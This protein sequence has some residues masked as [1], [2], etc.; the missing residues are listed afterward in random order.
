MVPTHHANER[1]E[2]DEREQLP[3]GWSMRERASEP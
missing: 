2:A 1:G 3:A